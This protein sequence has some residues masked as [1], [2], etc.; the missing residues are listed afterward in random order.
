MNLRY[1]KSF[2]DYGLLFDGLLDNVKSLFGY[3]NV[4]HRHDLD[5]RISTIRYVF[6]FSGGSISWRSILYKC[7]IQLTMEAKYV[8]ATEAAKKVI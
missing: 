7:V 2:V 3:V 1:L 5:K 4:D 8:A 6:T